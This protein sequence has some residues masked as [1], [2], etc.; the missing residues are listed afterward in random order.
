MGNTLYKGNDLDNE[1]N[2]ELD[3]DFK[4]STYNNPTC[5][6]SD[7]CECPVCMENTQLEK[8]LPCNH[9][10]CKNCI[11]LLINGDGKCPN[12]RTPFT[13]Y[14]CN[15]EYI[16]VDQV[17][18][19][20]EDN[21]I[22]IL[23]D[24]ISSADDNL[25]LIYEEYE[26]PFVLNNRDDLMNKSKIYFER[27]LDTSDPNTEM[28]EELYDAT[29]LSQQLYDDVYT[30]VLNGDKELALTNTKQIMKTL[31]MKQYKLVLDRFDDDDEYALNFVAQRYIDIHNWLKTIINLLPL[32][33]GKNRK[34]KKE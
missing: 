14:G 23:D 33:G 16:P 17:P 8:L 31:L 27:G 34:N 13:S 29:E 3:D 25:A 22:D 28:Y 1:L 2:N 18:D 30:T 12:C 26:K 6:N 11:Q 32:S 5:C 15:G 21:I 7:K 4:E 9:H 20:T 10:V 24:R 19:I